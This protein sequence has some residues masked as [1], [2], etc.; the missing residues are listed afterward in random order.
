MKFRMKTGGTGGS[1]ISI[2][3][4]KKRLGR[5]GVGSLREQIPLGAIVGSS[6]GERDRDPMAGG[7]E[8][9][10]D[11]TSTAPSDLSGISKYPTGR[12][13]EPDVQKE[14]DDL[15]YF[16]EME[17]VDYPLWRRERFGKML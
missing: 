5:A 10:D 12:A 7:W 9:T 14:V 1:K 4:F 2:Q 17:Q 16:S 3:F 8:G 6:T 13:Q 15:G 11:A